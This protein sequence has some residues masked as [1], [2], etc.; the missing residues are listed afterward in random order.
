MEVFVHVSTAY[1]NC[2]D[3]DAIK[4]GRTIAEMIRPKKTNPL[5][6]VEYIGSKSEKFII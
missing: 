5:K 4:E 2:D 1:V 3:V 6:I